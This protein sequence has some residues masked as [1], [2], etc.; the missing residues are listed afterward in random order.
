MYD[1]E[2]YEKIKPIY[3]EMPGST[4]SAFGVK[5]FEAL[6][7]EAQNYISAL[8]ELIQVP[9]AMISTGPERTETIV[10]QHPFKDGSSQ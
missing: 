4:Q 8:E 7:I 1:A 3:R 6:P 2:S 5:S 9:I 10:R